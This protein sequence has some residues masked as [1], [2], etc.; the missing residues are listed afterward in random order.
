M[1]L[2]SLV[3]VADNL[4]PDKWKRVGVALLRR[5]FAAVTAGHT[6]RLQAG[7]C[8]S[9]SCDGCANRLRHED[10]IVGIQMGTGR[11][12][13]SLKG[14]QLRVELPQHRLC[15]PV[16][17]SLEGLGLAQEEPVLAKAWRC[18]CTCVMI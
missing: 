18:A 10:V 2:T 4:L 5:G 15:C 1:L 14:T 13:Q 16:C 8:G 9:S 7:M 17:C 6:N 11:A 3:R 12:G